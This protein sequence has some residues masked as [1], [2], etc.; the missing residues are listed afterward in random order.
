MKKAKNIFHE[1]LWDYTEE[2]TGN[3]AID[4]YK[5]RKTDAEGVTVCWITPDGQ[6]IA[7]E[8][9]DYPNDSKCARVQEAIR[10]AKNEQEERKQKLVDAV[11]EDLK[12]SFKHKDY[13][14][15]DELLKFIPTKN[16]IQA[17]PEEQWTNYPVEIK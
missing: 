10:L 5:S 6:V 16:L 2:G 8:N 14:V 1:V 11:I 9:S 7:G 17:L 4:A 13:T 3:I 12:D 15:L